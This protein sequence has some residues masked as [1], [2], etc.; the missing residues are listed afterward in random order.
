MNRYLN[1]KKHF[2]PSN[3][4]KIIDIYIRVFNYVEHTYI[5]KYLY[6]LK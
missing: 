6:L 2:T 4:N 3:I 1:T 5:Q